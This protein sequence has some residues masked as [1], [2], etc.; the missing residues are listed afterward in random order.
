[1]KMS[2][3]TQEEYEQANTE[4]LE[5]ARFRDENESQ[6]WR[7][8]VIAICQSPNSVNADLRADDLVVEFRA[9]VSK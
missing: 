4:R 8:I 3:P 9:R 5:H 1:M 6:L 7:D 2:G